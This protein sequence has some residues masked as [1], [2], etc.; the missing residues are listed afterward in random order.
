MKN[1]LFPKP[2]GIS[3]HA[4]RKFAAPIIRPRKKRKGA[5]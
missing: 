3:A 2:K 5:K 4:W 1:V